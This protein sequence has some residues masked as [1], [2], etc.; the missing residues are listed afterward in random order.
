MKG[1][2]RLVRGR[3]GRLSRNPGLSCAICL[4][5][6][7]CLGAPGARAGDKVLARIGGEVITQGELEARWSSLPK[8]VQ[9]A[10]AKPGGA[11]RLLEQMI[12]ERLLVVAAKDSA[13]L[14]GAGGSKE[15]LRK[16]AADFWESRVR[17][18][19]HV[20]E[21]DAREYFEKHRDE[22]GSPERVRLRIFSTKTKKEA[23]Q[24]R[25]KLQDGF[26]PDSLPGNYFFDRSAARRHGMLGYFAERDTIPGLRDSGRLVRKAFKL[27]A[28]K[29]SKPIRH[30]G[31]FHLLLV[32]E[33]V[34]AVD[35]EFDDL[36][37]EIER[38]L[39]RHR[40]KEAYQAELQLLKS[41]YPVKIE[42][43]ADAVS[44][45]RYKAAEKL[46]QEAQKASSSVQRV[47][48]YKEL[49]DRYADTKYGCQA[50]FM[51]AF[52]Y[53][54]EMHEYDKARQ[55]FESMIARFPECDLVESA[56]WMLENMEKKNT[57]WESE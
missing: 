34:P 25:R 2:P 8:A 16:A 23:R 14:R 42:S 55:A 4:V 40:F 36:S 57:P 28:G 44:F 38:K 19:V 6:A 12:E 20:S 7:L 3:T 41:V 50:A 24:L 9:E 45:G 39:F 17:A 43:A 22:L 5:L 13:G 53:A 37:A 30:R 33:R 51:I 47:T 21:E 15:D 32:E 56:K 26:S 10:Y 31:S 35:A 46:F 49:L 27:K 1:K 54:E 18:R 48:V 52:V 11:R 29:L